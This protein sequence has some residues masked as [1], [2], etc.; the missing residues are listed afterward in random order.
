MVNEIIPNQMDEN[1]QKIKDA[2]EAWRLPYW[3]WAAN[4]EV[5]LLAQE[6][7]VQVT[8]K[9]GT[10]PIKNPLYQYDL[11][12][13]KTFGTMGPPSNQIYALISADGVPVS[14]SN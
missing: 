6:E 1:D 2:A 8:T 11:P 3:D 7:V 13:G 9:F 4:N 14:I 12:K 10:S 5:P